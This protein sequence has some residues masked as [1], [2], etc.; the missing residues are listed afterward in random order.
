M[1]SIVHVIFGSINVAIVGV[2]CRGIKQTVY[3]A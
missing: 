3:C 2:A 1:H